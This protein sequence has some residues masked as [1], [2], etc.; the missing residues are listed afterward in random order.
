[1]SSNVSKYLKL[2]L[3]AGAFVVGGL[4]AA[5]PAQ[6]G[7]YSNPAD[8]AQHFADCAKWMVSDQAKHAKFCSPGHTVFVSGSTGFGAPPC[9]CW[10]ECN[11]W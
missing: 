3:V 9:R 4:A 5:A 2:A 10:W 8:A 1:M 6:A 7:K 11:N